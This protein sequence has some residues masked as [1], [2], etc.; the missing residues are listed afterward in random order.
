MIDRKKITVI[1]GGTG[2]FTI[3]SGLKKY[4]LSLKV[5]VSM[6]DSGGSTGRLR[7]QLGVLP[8]GDFRQCLVALSKSQ[9]LWRKLFLYR[10][11]K[12]DLDGHNFGNIF[13]TALEKN[14]KNYQEVV[15]IA[16]VILNTIGEV[17]PVTF[18]KTNLCVKYADKDIIKRQDKI[19]L[20]RHKKTRIEKV[21]LSPKVKPNKKALS[22]IKESDFI[23]LGPGD[24]YTSIIPNLVFKEVRDAF[25]KTKAKIVYVSNL[26]NKKG[27][28]TNFKVSDYVFELEKYIGRKLDVIIVNKGSFD[29]NL[30]LNYKKEGD[31]P[32]VD[33]LNSDKRVLRCSLV[34]DKKVVIS[35]SDK[36]KRSLIRHDSQKIAKVIWKLASDNEPKTWLKKLLSY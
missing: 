11:D 32:A 26:M 27:Q 10:F 13:L 15:E 12:G 30:V 22:A 3:L 8:P 16:S 28:T 2:T 17:I 6:M 14:C 21:F 4:P 23:I 1:G 9:L 36:M 19:D 18:E 5:I 7:D 24:L 31:E 34:S 25:L 33:D 35:K 29:K 20:A